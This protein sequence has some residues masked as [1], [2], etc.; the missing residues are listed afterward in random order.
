MEHLVRRQEQIDYEACTLQT[1]SIET[2]SALGYVPSLGGNV[3]FIVIFALLIPFQ[4]YLGIRH[5]TWGYMAG[6][7]GGLILEIIGYVARV[8]ANSD[9]FGENPF[10]MFVDPSPFRSRVRVEEEAPNAD[11]NGMSLGRL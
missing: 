11:V 9:P 6:L 8:Q 7:I 4:V 3:V 1:C 5:R 2:D 10:L